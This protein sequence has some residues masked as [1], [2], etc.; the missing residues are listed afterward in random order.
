MTVARC[1][2]CAELLVVD[3]VDGCD[4]RSCSSCRGTWIAALDLHALVQPGQAATEAGGLRVDAI[5][6]RADR[7][8]PYCTEPLRTARDGRTSTEIDWCAQHGVWLDATELDILR[9]RITLP[10]DSKVGSG[11]GRRSRGVMAEVA[12]FFGQLFV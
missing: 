1:P 12:L 6:Q 4:V 10:R 11:D 8:C 9:G 7:R 2:V 3:E 5:R